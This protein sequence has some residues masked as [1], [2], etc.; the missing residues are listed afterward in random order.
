MGFDLSHR[1]VQRNTLSIITH[2]SWKILTLYLPLCVFISPFWKIA[3]YDPAKWLI[4]K[5]EFCQ[6]KSWVFIK[7]ETHYILRGADLKDSDF[8]SDWCV[9]AGVPDKLWW[10]RS[11]C[12]ISYWKANAR[13]MQIKNKKKKEWFGEGRGVGGGGRVGGVCLNWNYWLWCDRALL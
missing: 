8:Q 1:L 7:L 3:C 9:Q 4:L 6:N 2:F 13:E 10:S 11:L 12:R 5:S